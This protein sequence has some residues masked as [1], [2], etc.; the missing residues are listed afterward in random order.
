MPFMLI[1]QLFV[2]RHK[3]SSVSKNSRPVG[4]IT[5]WPAWEIPHRTCLTT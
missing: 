5:A 2:I 3:F 1:R 4:Q